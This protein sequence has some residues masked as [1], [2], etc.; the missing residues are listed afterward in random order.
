MESPSLDAMKTQNKINSLSDE[1]NLSEHNNSD[2]MGTDMVATEQSSKSPVQ[3][4]Q[5]LNEAS[6]ISTATACS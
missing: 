2:A 3:Q 4:Q 6:P 1:N 5:Q